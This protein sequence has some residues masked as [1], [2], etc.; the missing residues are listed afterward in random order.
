MRRGGSCVTVT[1][2]VIVISS[3]I[4]GL[5]QLP[6]Q[7]EYIDKTINT[8][9]DSTRKEAFISISVQPTPKTFPWHRKWSI[10]AIIQS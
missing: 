5:Q 8:L 9:P 10:P 3:T 6:G 4:P 2:L 1:F 7:Y